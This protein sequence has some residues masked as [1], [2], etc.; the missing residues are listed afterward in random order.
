MRAM[1]FLG[2]MIL[3]V[4]LV[5]LAAG[6]A[7]AAPPGNDE[8][9][10]AVVINLGDRLTEDTTQ[11]TTNSGDDALNAN[12][13]APF[14]NASVW[15][16]FTPATTTPVVF[17]VTES[18]YSAGLMVFKGTPTADSLVTC[19]PGIVGLR[20]QGGQTYYVMAFSD[21]AVNGG[22]LVL[23]LK[24]APTPRAHV[25]LSKRGL[26]FHGGAGAARIH[27]TYSCKHDEGFSGLHA[28]LTQRAGRLK[29]KGDAFTGVQCDGQRHRWSAKVVS[30]VGTYAAGR[31]VG[32]VRIDVCGFLECRHDVAKHRVHLRWASS[33][34]RAVSVHPSATRAV[35]AHPLVSLQ[36]RWPT[37]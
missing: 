35:D 12:C 32:K 3:A 22:N 33:S 2:A 26:A 16:Q 19:G 11:A 8:V 1:R 25:A 29:I 4:A 6:A 17:D 14:T 34:S 10:G 36:A 21:T 24:K 13:G 31:A 30:P 5:P 23:S 7:Q 28:H 37:S 15:Y 27:G 20:A 18:D 9:G